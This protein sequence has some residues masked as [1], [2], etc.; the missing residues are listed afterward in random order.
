MFELPAPRGVL[1]REPN[2]LQC[3]PSMIVL[4]QHLD[5]RFL[6]GAEETPLSAGVVIVTLT[7]VLP[8]PNRLVAQNLVGSRE[9]PEVLARARTIALL[10]P[11]PAKTG[12]R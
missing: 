5:T 8:I 1:D 3:D 9:N 11:Q 10:Q 6:Q 4:S 12:S 2:F 7:I